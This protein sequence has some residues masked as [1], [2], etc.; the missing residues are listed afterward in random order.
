MIF[1]RHQWINR[2]LATRRGFEC[3]RCGKWRAS[4]L[5]GLAPAYHRTQDA[6]MTARVV[7]GIER[8]AAREQ[9]EVAELERMARKGNR[10]DFSHRE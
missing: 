9:E 2:T 10:D 1:C 5:D 6:P 7:T 3:L 8:E 4:I